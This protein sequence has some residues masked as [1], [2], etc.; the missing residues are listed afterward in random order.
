MKRL[1]IF[2]LLFIA[3][4]LS[5]C[6]ITEKAKQA[7]DSVLS[8]KES[9]QAYWAC[10]DGC[11]FMQKIHEEKYGLNMTKEDHDICAAMCWSKYGGG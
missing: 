9:M 11:L 10:M 8:F 4:V 5:G 6:S 1:L 2:L 3:L 7:K